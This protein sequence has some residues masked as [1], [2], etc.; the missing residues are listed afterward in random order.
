MQNLN[1]LVFSLLSMYENTSNANLCGHLLESFCYNR[2]IR[3]RLKKFDSVNFHLLRQ[4]TWKCKTFGPLWTTSAT[5]FENANNHLIKT[6]TGSVNTCSLIVSCYIRKRQLE[7]FEVKV[8]HLKVYIENL[9]KKPTGIKEGLCLERNNFYF[10][11]KKSFLKPFPSV[12]I[13]GAFILIFRIIQ[14]QD[15]TP[16]VLLLSKRTFKP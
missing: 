6:L 3:C 7:G 10:K 8:D 2:S 4:L 5:M 12:D 16:T 11:P 9:R 14:D 13:E 15:Q 1:Y